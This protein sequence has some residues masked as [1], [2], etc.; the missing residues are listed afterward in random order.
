LGAGA[1]VSLTAAKAFLGELSGESFFIQL[2]AS[3]F[4]GASFCVTTGVD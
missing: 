2:L 4:F 1:L 3:I